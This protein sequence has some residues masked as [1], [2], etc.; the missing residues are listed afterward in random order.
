MLYTVYFVRGR[1]TTTIIP[2]ISSVVYKIYTLLMIALMVVLILLAAIETTRGPIRLY[3]SG[4]KVFGSSVLRT[5]SRKVWL[6]DAASGNQVINCFS[7]CTG[8]R[9]AQPPATSFVVLMRLFRRWEKCP[10][11]EEI[12][13]ESYE[14]Y[15]AFE[16]MKPPQTIVI[17]ASLN[18]STG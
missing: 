4:R 7:V 5:D 13:T 17:I 18:F 6:V 3:S 2:R 8:S 12:L 15:D 1:T 16:R 11:K 10:W 9:Q 14:T